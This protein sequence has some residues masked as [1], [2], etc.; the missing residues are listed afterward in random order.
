MPTNVPVPAD[1]TDCVVTGWGIVN[2]QNNARP[3]VLQQA[4]LQMISD[5]QCRLANP[6]QI[7]K[8]MI[9]AGVAQGGTDACQGDSGGPLVCIGP[10]SV[11][12][13]QGV[14]S[15]GDDCAVQGNYSVFAKVKYF[16][17]WIGKQILAS[18]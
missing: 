2:I 6:I 17:A 16:L 3:A 8:T 10:G 9:C 12:F 4:N 11:Y 1:G 7:D 18:G 13:L 14:V 5:Q 15:W